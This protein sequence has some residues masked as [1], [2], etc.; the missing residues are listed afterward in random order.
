MEPD[1]LLARQSGSCIIPSPPAISGKVCK[2]TRRLSKESM[3]RESLLK[4]PRVSVT[5]WCIERAGEQV[6]LYILNASLQCGKF[7]C[8]LAIPSHRPISSAPQCD[9]VRSWA[10]AC[11]LARSRTTLK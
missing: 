1:S 2:L 7:R 11:R 8:S 3:H 6:M 10:C 9:P 4:Q 5:H